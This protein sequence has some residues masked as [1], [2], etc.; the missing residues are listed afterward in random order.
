MRPQPMLLSGTTAPLIW[1]LPEFT[2]IA[3][4]S[5]AEGVKPFAGTLAP[6]GYQ[7]SVR[8]CRSSAVQ[9]VA[10]GVAIDVPLSVAYVESPEVDE[11]TLAPGAQIVGLRRLSVVG[12]R[13]E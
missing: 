4:S 5:A 10:A 1:L 13:L 9:P 6:V 12:P 11:V 2:T 8:Y 7:P 3:L